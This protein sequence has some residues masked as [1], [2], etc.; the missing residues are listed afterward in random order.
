MQGKLKKLKTDDNEYIYPITVSDAVYVDPNTNLKTLL[1][2]LQAGMGSPVSYLIQAESWGIRNDGTEPEATTKGIND[3]LAWAKEKGYNHVLLPGG[4]YSV[5]IDSNGT[6]ISMPGGMHLELHADCV[7]QLQANSSPSYRIIEV[8]G[9]RHAK[10]SGGTLIGDKQNHWFEIFVKFTRGGVNADGSLNDDP[11]F[12]R[13]EVIDRYANP[14]LL[15]NFRLWSIDG[16]AATSYSFYQYKDT[17]SKDTFVNLRNNGGFA[18]AAPTGR[19]WFDTIDNANKMVFVIDISSSPLTDEQIA[20]ISAKIDNSYYTHESGLGIGILSSNYVEVSGVE[21]ANCTGDGILTG[22]GVYYDD[23]SQYSQEQI[24]QH[25]Y[26]HDCTIHHCRRQ[27]MSLCGPNDVYVM[28]N[29]IHHIGYADDGTTSDFRNGI[30]PMFGID[31]ESMVGES[32]IPFKSIYLNQTSGL[33]TNYRIYIY[34]NY[35]HHNARGHFV[36]A[37]GTYITLQNNT[38]E[39]YTVGGVSSYQNQW[40][41]KYIN[42]TFIG[43]SLTVSGNNFVN[44]AVLN[45]AHLNLSNVQ[46]AFVDNCQIKDGL[47][48]GSSIY[49]YFGM[50]AAVDVTTGTFTYNTPHGMGNGAQISFEQW[51]GKVP[52]GISVDKLYYTVNVT[53]ISFQVSETKG[54]KPVT[55]TDAGTSG[56]NIS[57]YNYGRC[58]ISNITVEK[59]WRDNNNYDGSTGFIP[60]VAGAAL[61]NITVKNCDVSI[62]PPDN[63][64]GRPNTIDGLTIIEGTG[65]LQSSHISNLKAMRAK[66]GAMGGDITLGTNNVYSKVNLDGALFQGVQVNFGAANLSNGTFL[67]AKI[68]KP[69]SPNTAAITKSYME[70]TA[71]NLHWLTYDG[72]MTIAEC[73]FNNVTMD[74]SAAVRL[75]GN[76]DINS[77]LTDNRMNA[78]PV[79]GK[80]ALGQIIYNASPAPGGY[81]GWICTT[82]GYAS[83]LSWSAGKAY[84]K[85]SRIVAAGHVYEAQNNGTSGSA[86]P[87]FPTASGG[88]ITDNDMMWKEIGLLAVFKPFG[89]IGT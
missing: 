15:S 16:I 24:G 8:K 11:N 61:K 58:Y 49:G 38:F 22:I 48:Y 37:D 57:R 27:G 30:P 67:N 80:Y 88:T 44:G 60:L 72:A 35:I 41:V 25:I 10:I 13:S 3:A 26:I 14:G 2:Q 40:Y 20:Q 33:E 77:G 21:I 4:T 56:F 82:A 46:G 74:A 54:G 84:S 69:D 52:S 29:T 64:V 81:V 85:G 7:L 70:N 59:D 5:Q 31:I 63:Y 78:V 47:F 32:N 62:K 18:P 66:T 36:N 83:N 89:L 53:S 12:I 43:G 23:P 51:F 87:A 42:N 73:L 68:Y 86:V 79:S 34:N 19:G 55:I 75:L 6:A 45:K 28:N 17:V 76:L 1:G 9:V 39:G 50:P 71:I 65:N